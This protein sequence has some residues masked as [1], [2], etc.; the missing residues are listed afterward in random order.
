MSKDVL[1]RGSDEEAFKGVE[2]GCAQ[3]H[4]IRTSL[5]RNVMG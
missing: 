1:G 3:Q 4:E 5:F 2:A